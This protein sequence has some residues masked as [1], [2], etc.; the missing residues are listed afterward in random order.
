MHETMRS[1]SQ[2]HHGIHP[3]AENVQSAFG[4]FSEKADSIRGL[5]SDLV[6]GRDVQTRPQVPEKKRSGTYEDG[7]FGDEENSEVKYRTLRWWCVCAGS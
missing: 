7:P 4:D 1:G 2:V 6:A 5:P 3:T